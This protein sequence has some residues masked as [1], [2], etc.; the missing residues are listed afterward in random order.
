MYYL[1]GKIASGSEKV[2]DESVV[3]DLEASVVMSS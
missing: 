1:E 2:N 3:L